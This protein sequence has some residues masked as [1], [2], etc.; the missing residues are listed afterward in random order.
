MGKEKSGM[1]ELNWGEVVSFVL[2]SGF[3]VVCGVVRA[4]FYRA[5]GRQFL[6][7]NPK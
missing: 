6:F 3:A 4:G 7:S 2:G 1:L 5:D